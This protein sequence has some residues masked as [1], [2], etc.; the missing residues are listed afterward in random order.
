[1]RRMNFTAL[2]LW[3][4]VSTASML[5]SA[6]DAKPDGAPPAAPA[7]DAKSVT[8]DAVL[9]TWI[10]ALEK[11]DLKAANAFAADEKATKEMESFWKNLKAAH[12]KHDYRK[13][14]A[15]T[16]DATA[17]FKV[18]G[19]KFNHMHVDWEKG[20]AGWRIK[21]VWMCR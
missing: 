10:V 18:G 20:D 8:L 4:V 9:E 13:L 21:K 17:T 3:V 6:G 1:M 11:D 16:K 19:H 14:A 2:A 7:G 12:A 5:A 15:G